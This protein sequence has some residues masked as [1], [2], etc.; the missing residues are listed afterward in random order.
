MHLFIRK[1]LAYA[2]NRIEYIYFCLILEIKKIGA[3]FRFCQYK[4]NSDSL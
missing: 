1:I 2:D 3:K 4:I